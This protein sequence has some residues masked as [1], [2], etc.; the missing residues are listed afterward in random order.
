MSA[1]TSIRDIACSKIPIV[2]LI[3]SSHFENWKNIINVT[4]PSFFVHGR[5]DT[6]IPY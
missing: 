5:A 1:Y 4:C 6:L 3:M 2:G